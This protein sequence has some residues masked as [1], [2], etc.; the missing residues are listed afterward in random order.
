[1]I[2]GVS[3]YRFPRDPDHTLEKVQNSKLPLGITENPPYVIFGKDGPSG[4]EIEMIKSFAQS[5]N[6]EVEWIEGSEEEIM[7]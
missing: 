6:A 1:M 5:L 3:C 2:T 7:K 4:K